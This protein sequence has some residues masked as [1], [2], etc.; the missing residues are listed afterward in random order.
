MSRLTQGP[1]VDGDA[2]NAASLNDRFT[3]F[4]QSGALNQFNTRDGAFDL[5]QFE[6]GASRFLVPDFASATIGYDDWKHSASNTYTGQTTGASPFITQNAAPANTVLSL[7]AAGFTLQ[8]STHILRVYWDLSVKPYWNGSKP[9][10]GGASFFTFPPVAALSEHN[11]GALQGGAPA[12]PVLVGVQGVFAPPW[13]TGT[14]WVWVLA[15]NTYS[16]C[17]VCAGCR[18]PRYCYCDCSC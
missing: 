10:T 6:T 4:T 5:P 3:Q 14:P 17:F 7:G 16:L 11:S 18:S 15:H 12:L 9:W 2:I 1:I 8:P 13:T